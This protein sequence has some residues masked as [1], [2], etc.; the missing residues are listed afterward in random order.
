MMPTRVAMDLGGQYEILLVLDNNDWESEPNIHNHTI[1]SE[2]PCRWSLPKTIHNA[3]NANIV[4]GCI[5]VVPLY[6]RFN[7]LERVAIWSGR[8]WLNELSVILNMM[9][10]VLARGAAVANM[11]GIPPFRDKTF[12]PY[13]CTVVI[14]WKPRC[15]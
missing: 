4:V 2:C 12:G 9:F 6:C 10:P 11:I 15:R 14:F 8:L 3:T 13:R 1:G 7:H 5:Y